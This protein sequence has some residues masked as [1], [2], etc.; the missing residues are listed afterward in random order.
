MSAPMTLILPNA[1]FPDL[2][3]WSDP[4]SAAVAERDRDT[5]GMVEDAVANR[6]VRL[7]YQPVVP[8]GNP[9]RPVFYEGLAR[10][11]DITGRPIPAAEFMGAVELH[12]TGRLIDSLALELGLKAL[13]ANPGIRL[14]INMSAR[15]IGYPRWTRTLEAGLQADPSLAGRLILEVTE[16]SAMLIPDIVS[17]FMADLQGRGVR[18]AL[19]DFGQG[20]T[21]FRYLRDFDF[22]ILKIDGQFIRGVATDPDNQVLTRALVSIAGHFQMLTVAESV[23]T[24]ADAAWLAGAGVDCLQGYHIAAPTL[25]PTWTACEERRA[26]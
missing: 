1:P 25:R 11:L 9:L 19:D 26:V 3:D 23:E 13:H 16:S 2:P 20:F 5:L 4:L 14:S 6:R 18:F 10:I 7:A 24:A 22:D 17:V 15:S 21:P 12:E 8:A